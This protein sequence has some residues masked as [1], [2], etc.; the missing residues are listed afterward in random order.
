M[1]FALALPTI[2]PP[3]ELQWPR[4]QCDNGKCFWFGCVCCGG[5]DKWAGAAKAIARR[6]N[7]VALLMSYRAHFVDVYKDIGFCSFHTWASISSWCCS[8]LCAH[9]SGQLFSSACSS[10]TESTQKWESFGKHGPIFFS[11]GSVSDCVGCKTVHSLNILCTVF[12]FVPA[13]LQTEW[14]LAS[15]SPPVCSNVLSKPQ[16]SP[17]RLCLAAHLVLSLQ[18]PLWESSARDHEGDFVPEGE[19]ASSKCQQGYL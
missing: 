19:E 15:G 11:L 9:N 14:R 17:Q 4:S 18:V 13:C 1:S 8:M 5:W 16:N 12:L 3:P 2:P 7:A 10:R 6:R